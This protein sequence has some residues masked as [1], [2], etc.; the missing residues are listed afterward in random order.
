MTLYLTPI[1]I[2]VGLILVL[3]TL[4]YYLTRKWQFPLT[5]AV[6]STTAD[7][8]AITV[9][10]YFTGG[11][12]SMFFTLYLVQ[13]LGVSLFLNL[14]FSAL[15][16]AWAVILVGTMKILESVGLIAT[17]SQFIPVTYSEFT[18]TIIWLTFQAMILCL[19]AF[20]GGNLSNKLY[21]ASSDVFH[22]HPLK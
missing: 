2:V 15:M 11:F 18:D 21:L 8:V 6:V 16:I 14:P 20:L 13:I 12:N 4:S 7:V 10:V 5:V 1:H 22:C 17:S 19:V 9:L 3:N